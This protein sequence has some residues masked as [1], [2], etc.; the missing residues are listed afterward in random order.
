MEGPI[1][2]T[3]EY[4]NVAGY[5]SKM[6]SMKTI[7]GDTLLYVGLSDAYTSDSCDV[8]GGKATRVPV[9]L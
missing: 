1:L 7:N 3:Q 2:A 6:T 9:M 8:L 4:F 5:K